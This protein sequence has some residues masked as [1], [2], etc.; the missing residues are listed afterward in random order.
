M[1]VGSS[2]LRLYEAG[3]SSFTAGQ[4][5][6]FWLSDAGN[7][8][9]GFNPINGGNYLLSVW[10]SADANKTALWWAGLD[11]N[12]NVTS[13]STLNFTIYGNL[14]L[15][16]PQGTLLW[17][18]GSTSSSYAQLQDTG[19]LALL[20]EDNMSIS[21]QSFDY[22]CDSLM[23]S[24][25]QDTIVANKS[26]LLQSRSNQS[27]FAPGRFHIA[28]DAYLNLYF[29]AFD[30]LKNDFIYVYA[31]MN[32]SRGLQIDRDNL[33]VFRSSA[34]SNE[35]QRLTLDYDGN[36][37]VY[38]W[39]SNVSSWKV[40]WQMLDDRC[41][42]GSPCGPFGLCEEV[43]SSTNGL[44][45]SCP[46]GYQPRVAGDLS[47]GC[48]SLISFNATCGTNTT[49]YSPTMV[50]VSHS[51][52]MYDDITQQSNVG[53]NE[54]KLLC[55]NNCD[56][57]AASFREDGM[58]FIK[59]NS[60]VGYLLNGYSA[61]T[62][63]VL[64]KVV[65]PISK[66][67]SK[68]GHGWVIGVGVG[69]PIAALLLVAL[70]YG[71]WLRRSGRGTC[72][73]WRRR[74]SNSFEADGP[75]RYFEYDELVVATKNFSEKLG[76]GGF[77][78]VYKGW[79]SV[80]GKRGISHLE[81][82]L[83]STADRSTRQ[84]AVA[85]KFLKGGLD[86]ERGAGGA[87]TQFR[88]EVRTL[89]NVHHVNLVSLVG[90]CSRRRHAREQRLLVFEY[91]ENGSLDTFL[92]SSE[93]EQLPWAIR[94]SIALGAARG[95]AYLHHE[96]SPPIMHCDI[97]PHNILLDN[98]F[99]AKV[100]DFGFARRF[101]LDSH[102]TMSGIRGT[103][104]YLAP[105]WLTSQE[106]TS[107]VDVYSFG[108]LLL[109]LVRGFKSI[110]DIKTP[111]MEWA[112]GCIEVG[113]VVV[114]QPVADDESK[115]IN[116]SLDVTTSTQ[117]QDNDSVDLVVAAEKLRVLKVGM[118]CIQ[119]EPSMRPAMSRVVQLIDGTIPIEDPPIPRCR[120]AFVLPH[121]LISESD[122][123][124]S[125]T[126]STNNDYSYSVVSAR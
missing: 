87:E 77:G 118:W 46:P 52:Y 35:L 11:N 117:E 7:Y 36:L 102:I 66:V 8:T 80:G 2:A 10:H 116:T 105:E 59:G 41:M 62:N 99:T 82:P 126:T 90:Y 86:E 25:L 42:L 6:S 58:C 29:H 75:V 124:S 45:C 9:F 110:D 65:E 51:D 13:G 101:R 28:T 44:N 16:S 89:G 47:Q 71:A 55:L 123:G 38:M 106:L 37:R 109:E 60:Q 31:K 119:A 34:S 54:C 121:S 112:I 53:L 92:S 63:T 96:C 72:W 30:L 111:L 21:W 81:K 70:C 26:S 22:P 113:A 33:I 104:G 83:V 84:L 4:K 115:V 17:N 39:E 93:H 69:V 5:S 57:M 73:T 108:M 48:E 18:S 3:N 19:N 24:D 49:S 27:S 68:H 94:Y 100:A 23:L 79:V 76:E 40:V 32:T 114:Q 91:L 107:K 64:I 120:S 85:V 78:V 1:P 74:R 125:A 61:E 56:C 88:A 67:S 95:I 15:R 97:K 12:P 20:Q 50:E 43:G 98:Q 14:E 103:R 122:Y